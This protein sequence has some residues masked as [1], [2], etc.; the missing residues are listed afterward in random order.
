MIIIKETKP[1]TFLKSS[2]S[3]DRRKENVITLQGKF[4]LLFSLGLP[5]AVFFFRRDDAKTKVERSDVPLF[6]SRFHDH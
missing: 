2:A 3:Y 1:Q 6:S 4:Q 5:F